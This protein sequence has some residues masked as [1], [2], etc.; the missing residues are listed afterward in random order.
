MLKTVWVAGAL[1]GTAS[2]EP[3][4]LA[5]MVREVQQEFSSAT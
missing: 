3:T 2:L 4:T 5:A 1:I